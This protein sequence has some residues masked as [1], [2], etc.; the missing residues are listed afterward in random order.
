[1]LGS[2]YAEYLGL[3]KPGECE[4]SPGF[5]KFLG[6]LIDPIDFTVKNWVEVHIM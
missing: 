6:I 4:I 2:A 5:S 1:M 3:P